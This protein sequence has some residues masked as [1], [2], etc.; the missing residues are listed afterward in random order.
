MVFFILSFIANIGIT[1]SVARLIWRDAPQTAAVFGPDTPARRI[2]A[3]VYVSIG[4][5]SLLGLILIAAGHPAR[6]VQIAVPL[7]TLQITYKLGTAVAVG[8]RHPVVQANLAISA[9]LAFTL[10]SH[11]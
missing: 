4:V 2:L 5:L 6:A 7:F 8:L 9:L 1:F 11:L 10:V 3:C